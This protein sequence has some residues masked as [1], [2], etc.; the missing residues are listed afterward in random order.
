[1][2]IF[3]VNYPS[4]TPYLLCFSLGVFFAFQEALSP[5][6]IVLLTLGTSLFFGHQFSLKTLPFI[7]FA[8]CF[9]AL[10]IARVK[11]DQ[12]LPKSFYSIYTNNNE[13]DE[14][15]FRITKLLRKSEY[16]YRFYAK[17]FSTNA[18]ACRGKILLTIDKSKMEQP[19]VGEEYCFFGKLTPL[20]GPKNPFEFDYRR[21]LNYQGVY[22]QIK[23][24][25]KEQ[26]HYLNYKPNRFNEFN[27][28]LNEKISK[29]KLNQSSQIILK[30]MLL[31]QGEGMDKNTRQNFANA[32]VIH[33]FAIS[34][35]HIGLLMLMFQWIL[36]PLQFLPHGRIGQSIG[37]LILLWGYAFLIG[38]SPSVIRSVTLFSSFQ[39]GYLSYRKLPTSYLVLLSMGIL[40]FIHPRFI[41]ELGFQMSYLAVFG[42]LFLQPLMHLNLASKQLQWFWNLTTVCLAAQ[43]AV[44]PLSI[45]HFHQFPILFLLSNWII[46][47]F[48]GAFLYLGFGSLLL[49]CL[50]DL[51][52]MLT[53]LLNEIVEL[54]NQFVF[55]VSDQKSFLLL[56][57]KLSL[58]QLLLCYGIIVGAILGFG[59]K[60]K[61]GYYFMGLAILGFQW[62]IQKPIENYSPSVWVTHL[63][64]KSLLVEKEGEN[65]IFHSNNSLSNHPIIQN[66]RNNIRHRTWQI[67]SL[68]NIYGIGNQKLYIVDGSWVE[69]ETIISSSIILLR[70]NPKINL[71]RFL[72]NH[73]PYLV[74]IDGSNTSYFINRWQ[75]DL[76]SLN[77]NHW[78]TSHR[79]AYRFNRENEE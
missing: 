45:Y 36:R 42:I 54:F 35:L 40:L 16:H 77:Q 76:I 33:L 44:A 23:I 26:L 47:P 39:L 22:H 63:N 50:I 15:E 34:G 53:N 10:G 71:E 46:L 24:R 61:I 75:K 28:F 21:Y 5:W 9:F 72:L 52:L 55:W 19:N 49:L 64:G 57:L 79:G 65:L 58:I 2:Y 32:G 18:N 78:I 6:A 48:V 11:I 37:T 25:E 3:R 56:N 43:I 29:S 41:V 74:I 38:T 60:K 66:F 13:N 62:T 67:D 12:K 8:M 70:E 20:Q 30:T 69:N 14:F 1:M 51:P 17:V 27:A 7:C 4:L 73:A 68:K 59:Y 31:G